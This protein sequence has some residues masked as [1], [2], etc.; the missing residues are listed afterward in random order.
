MALSS[1]K[2]EYIA[3]SEST[4]IVSR[5]RRVFIELNLPLVKTVIYGGNNGAIEMAAGPTSKQLAKKTG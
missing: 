2:T 5:L 3:P 4:E 1:T